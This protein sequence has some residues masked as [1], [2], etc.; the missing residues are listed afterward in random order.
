MVPIVTRCFGGTLI[1]KNS[2]RPI[3]SS[4]I[5]CLQRRGTITHT[6]RSFQRIWVDVAGVMR[7]MN[8]QQPQPYE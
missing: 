2:V 4:S 1:P 3:D 6:E 5:V 7:D 8:F